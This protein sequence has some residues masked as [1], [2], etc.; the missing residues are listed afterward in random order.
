M[1]VLVLSQHYWPETFRITEV[2]ASLRRRG[3][4]VSVLTGQ[5]NYP[6]GRVFEGYRA[7]SWARGE[8][9]GTQVYRVPLVPR[10]RGGALR[11]VLNYLSFIASACTFGPWLLRRERIDVVFVYAT[12]PLLQAIAALWIGRLKGA[13]VV[14]WVQDLWPDSLEATGYVRNPRLLGAVAA[15]VRWIY[16]H[17]DL[18]LAQ[19][20]A[21]VASVQRLAGAT[22][23]VYHPNPGDAPTAAAPMGE[24]ALRLEPG[25]N[26]IFA[27]NLGTVQS[28]ETVL[29]A[30]ERLRGQRGLHWVLVGSGSRSAWL[31]A[32]VQRRGLQ[33]CMRLPGR[34][35]PAAMPAIFAQASA[36]LVSLVRSPIM[37]QTVP[38][39]VQAYLAAGRPIVASMDG[40][41]ARIV[42]EAGAGVTSPAEDA[43]ALAEAVL[44][45][46]AMDDAARAR[47]GENGSRYFARHFDADCLA[48]RLDALLAG[49][50][51]AAA[52]VGAASPDNRHRNE[53]P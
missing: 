33:E 6:E 1:R 12:S 32:E 24:P 38:S 46:R 42:Q 43:A 30:A 29:D 17:N 31:A 22:P 14:T 47:L 25:F 9:E 26:I 52:D 44:H 20:P 19:S 23:V 8:H 45:L 51:S 15:M 36:L 7:W 18:L 16:R 37:S 39:K 34:F 2:V 48:E 40:E 13:R 53:T 41:G 49:T 10:G 5:P 28:L 11:L 27:G 21:F 50:A 35:E 4:A 3:V